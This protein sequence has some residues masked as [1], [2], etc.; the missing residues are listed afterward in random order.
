MF[1]NNVKVYTD[2]SHF[3]GYIYRPTKGEGK[4]KKAKPLTEKMIVK[5]DR[6][7]EKSNEVT[8]LRDEFDEVY[9]ATRLEK[10]SVRAGKITAKLNPYFQNKEELK[11]FIG[12]NMAR[13]KK[14]YIGRIVRFR[15]KAYLNRFNYFVTFTYD[16]KLQTEETFKKRLLKCLQNMA[17]RYEWR[18]MGVWERGGKTGRLHFHALVYIPEGKMHGGLTEVRQY[19]TRRHRMVVTVQNDYFNERFG[20][21]DFE[22][23]SATPDVDGAI[24]YL[25]KYLE[26][27]M[28][29]IV[30]SR[31]LPDSF[32]CDINAD[33]VLFRYGEY[34][35]KL[36]LWDLFHCYLDGKDFGGVESFK[37]IMLY[38]KRK[39]G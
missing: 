27:S 32:R 28:E 37:E 7:V 12:R 17:S 10:N 21:C 11:D 35:D 24:A 19:D 33:H 36:M 5:E 14:A 8:T 2:G 29:R 6:S 4:K 39:K 1:Y 26:K 31:G 22:E 30:Y 25:C 15:R 38:A 9:E 20:R 13:K 3:M 18:Y 23:I 34:K 16:S